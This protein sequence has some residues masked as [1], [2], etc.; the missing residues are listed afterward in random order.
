MNYETKIKSGCS[1]TSLANYNPSMEQVPVVLQP[2][3]AAS[4]VV[5]PAYGGV[6]YKNQAS[7]GQSGDNSCSACSGYS[8]IPRAYPSN[9]TGVNKKTCI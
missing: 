9:Y 2:K 1:Y 8:R 3:L 5:I 4:Q 7:S 6:P